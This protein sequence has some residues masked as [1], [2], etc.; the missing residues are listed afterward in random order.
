[1]CYRL[2]IALGCL[3]TATSA[4][5]GLVLPASV[6]GSDGPLTTAVN[7]GTKT[8]NLSQAITGSWDQDNSADAGKG[9]YDPAKWAVVFKYSSVN[10][11]SG[12]T[13][14]FANHGSRAPVVWLVNG[15]VTI[16]G[17]VNLNGANYD[18]TVPSE[19]G[20][21]GFRGG[22]GSLGPTQ[23]ASG[24]FGPGGGYFPNSTGVYDATP[25]P[26]S[27]S[28]PVYGNA[29]ILP[30]IG[31]S[32]GSY[33]SGGGAG[34]G[35]ILIAATGTITVNGAIRARGGSTSYISGSGGAI[36]L[37]ADIVT[38]SGT[39]DA[40]SH[41]P[42][43]GGKGRIRIEA[44]TIPTSSTLNIAPE[45]SKQLPPDDPVLLWPPDNAPT[46]RVVSVGSVPVPVPDTTKELLSN[47]GPGAADLAFTNASLIPVIIETKN[48]NPATSVV[49]LRMTP[50]FGNATPVVASFT[51]GDT[52]SA[53]W[54]ATVILPQG[55]TAFQ[56]RVDPKP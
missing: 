3:A 14:T 51:S 22:E 48:I 25:S 9:V 56:A 2:L 17:I 38:G 28:A 52:T 19:P 35:A 42:S 44:N 40:S 21:G 50:R 26:V 32:G 49:T 54:V 45:P 8:I 10:I 11:A 41:D 46:A 34:G 4:R 31:G 7:S 53:L 39:L 12:S 1:M 16:T 5:A 30:L 29:R 15:D 27:G 37:I 20:P 36:K 23:P 18:G 6:N 33:S 47:L 43:W 55:Y 13:I 24:G